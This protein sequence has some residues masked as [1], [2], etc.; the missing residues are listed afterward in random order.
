MMD[1]R[2]GMKRQNTHKVHNQKEEFA[3]SRTF[4]I[5]IFIF[6]LI[7]LVIIWLF[8]RQFTS[9]G[10]LGL[11]GIFFVNFFASATVVVPLPG[12]ASVFLGGA[13][14]DPIAVGVVSGL[15]ASLGELLAYFVGFGGRAFVGRGGEQEQLIAMIE[16]FF[17]SAGFITTLVFS[18]LPVPVFDVIGLLAGSLNYPVWKFFFATLIGRV[19]RN[20]LIAWTGE[21]FLPV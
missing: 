21:K 18:A 3:S 1:K 17:H 7:L 8:R 15:G 14:L 19:G 20:I 13:V 11:L 10:H 16:K 2:V 6:A 9:M 5:C 12:V 4:R